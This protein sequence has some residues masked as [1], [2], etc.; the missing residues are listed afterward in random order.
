MATDVGRWRRDAVVAVG[1]AN[2]SR[3]IVGNEGDAACTH[4]TPSEEEWDRDKLPRE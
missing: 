1:A 4:V 2:S 3:S